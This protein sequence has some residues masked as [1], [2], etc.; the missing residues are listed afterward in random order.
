MSH[1]LSSTRP[2]TYCI[3]V[4]SLASVK[5]R[6]AGSVRRVGGRQKKHVT[7]TH[8][9]KCFVLPRQ[10]SEDAFQMRPRSINPQYSAMAAVIVFCQHSFSFLKVIQIKKIFATRLCS[11]QSTNARIMSFREVGWLLRAASPTATDKFFRS[12]CNQI[13]GILGLVQRSLLMTEKTK[14][15][16]HIMPA[17]IRFSSKIFP[18]YFCKKLRITV[19]WVLYT[20]LY[21]I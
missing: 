4:L 14:M 12:T 20:V 8:N 19:S 15:F 13:Q 16:C 2:H 3:H 7:P 6:D 5:G 18:S 11:Q 17:Y 21:Q 1:D 10:M 9:Y